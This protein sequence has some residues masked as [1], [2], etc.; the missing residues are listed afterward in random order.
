MKHEDR[1]F[2][3]EEARARV[4]D[5]QYLTLREFQRAVGLSCPFP[6]IGKWV[7]EARI[8]TTRVPGVDAKYVFER[9]EALRFI[10][11]R[12]SPYSMLEARFFRAGVSVI[13]SA[14]PTGRADTD[15][16][17]LH[18]VL[19]ALLDALG[20]VAYREAVEGAAKRFRLRLPKPHSKFERGFVRA[21][22]VLVAVTGATANLEEDR[23]RMHEAL[24]GFVEGFGGP[25][26]FERAVRDRARELGVV[27][28]SGPR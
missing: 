27:L 9:C 10:E 24:D 12:F 1:R 19:D 17:K 21:G 3:R 18:Q 8:T 25:R 16:A 26:A 5:G 13:A 22:I 23:S 20:A 6:A 4:P 11:N 15:L 14:N 28:R 7:A 2:S